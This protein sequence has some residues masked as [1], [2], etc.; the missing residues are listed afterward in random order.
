N[1]TF[2]LILAACLDS[3]NAR[4]RALALESLARMSRRAVTSRLAAGAMDDQEDQ[5]RRAAVRCLRT[6]G[7]SVTLPLV[8]RALNDPAAPVRA[9]A[10]EALRSHGAGALPALTGVKEGWRARSEAAL[11]RLELGDPDGVEH[12]RGLIGELIAT[13]QYF[14]AQRAAL[15]AGDIYRHLLWQILGEERAKL[16]RM[17]LRLGGALENPTAME[18]ALRG[19]GSD[20]PALRAAAREMAGKALPADLVGVLALFL[21]EDQDPFFL[22]AA[23]EPPARLTDLLTYSEPFVREIAALVLAPGQQSSTAEGR[24]MLTTIEKLMFLRAVPAFQRIPLED[25]RPLTDYVVVESYAAGESIFELEQE[26][27]TMYIIS[28]GRVSIR[29]YSPDGDQVEVA[30]LGP[31]QYFGEMSLFDGKPRSASAVAEEDTTVLSLARE[32]FLRLGARQPT[33]LVEVI[34]VL[35]GRLRNLIGDLDELAHR[36]R[37]A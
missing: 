26:G 8:A 20:R 23:D 24:P 14:T 9:E 1:Y 19:L 15:G 5:V 10:I 35:S 33:M 21:L 37:E 28:I 27:D 17:A 13:A 16:G 11:L 7:T 25:L 30:A 3:P 4:I 34:R 2:F 18:L 36:Q 12:A 22:S 29:H 32:P 6:Q 31:G